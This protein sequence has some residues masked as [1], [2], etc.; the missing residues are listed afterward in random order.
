MFV[1]E[2]CR[3]FSACWTDSRISGQAS[4]MCVESSK[5]A[6]QPDAR[7]SEALMNLGQGQCAPRKDSLSLGD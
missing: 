1:V 5:S 4:R 7:R 3:G 6:G 2:G